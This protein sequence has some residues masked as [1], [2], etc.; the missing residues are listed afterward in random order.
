MPRAASRHSVDIPKYLWAA[1]DAT[2]SA[3]HMTTAHLIS[4]WLTE[5]AHRHAGDLYEDPAAGRRLAEL[6]RVDGRYMYSPAVRGDRSRSALAAQIV[7]EGH[8]SPTLAALQR[9]ALGESAE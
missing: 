5:A 7:E 1:L 8:S 9:R 6:P 3:K 4:E 2:A